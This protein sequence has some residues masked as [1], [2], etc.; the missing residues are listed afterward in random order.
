MSPED[1]RK[2]KNRQQPK[3]SFR[4]V[5]DRVL[6]GLREGLDGLAEGLRP[7][8]PQPVPIPIPVRRPRRR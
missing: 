3:P 2:P 4:E 1:T 8:Q 6:E 7:P 5:L